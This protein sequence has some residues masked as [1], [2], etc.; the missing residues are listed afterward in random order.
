MDVVGEI[1]L[2]GNPIFSLVWQDSKMS[3]GTH[4]DVS[5]YRPDPTIY[6][7]KDK[8]YK[9]KISLVKETNYKGEDIWVLRRIKVLEDGKDYVY[10]R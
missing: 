8:K 4:T 3:I 5:A 9:A 6:L 10:V 7:N 1:W 2:Y